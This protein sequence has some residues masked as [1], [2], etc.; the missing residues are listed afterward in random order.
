MRSLVHEYRINKRLGFLHC[1]VL[2][3][4][5]PRG[6][7]LSFL[8]HY[9]LTLYTVHLIGSWSSTTSTDSRQPPILMTVTTYQAQPTTGMWTDLSIPISL[10]LPTSLWY[11]CQNWR[12]VSREKFRAVVTSDSVLI[13]SGEPICKE[14]VGYFH[15]HGLGGNDIPWVSGH[16]VNF[17]PQGKNWVQYYCQHPKLN[18]EDATRLHV[19]LWKRATISEVFKNTGIYREY[20]ISFPLWM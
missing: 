18:Y 19:V 3:I 16:G 20:D 2:W 14:D 12:S 10:Y 1:I 9:G 11:T 15:C 13:L 7:P 5:C 4:P 17:Q 8:V 6:L